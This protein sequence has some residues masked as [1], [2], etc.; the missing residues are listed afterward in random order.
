MVTATA[1]GSNDRS[2][3]KIRRQVEGVGAATEQHGA[4]GW[5][6]ALGE[7]SLFTEQVLVVNQK[8]KFFEVKAEYGVFD[9]HGHRIGAVREVGRSLMT[10]ALGQR[11]DQNRAVRLQV[12]DLDGRVRLTLTRPAKIL[13]S[14]VTIGLPDGTPVGQIVQKNLGLTGRIRFTLEQGGQVLGSINAESWGAWDFNVQDANENELARITRT[15]AGL[16]AESFTKGDNYVV[17]IHR[18][19]EEPLRSLVVAA[20]LAIDTALRQST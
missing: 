20:A 19:L 1:S 18:P 6:H 11:S 12:V 14:K 2:N 15:W 4:A 7:T 16:L 5:S 9:Q 10:K 3:K 17:Q 8:A 13:R